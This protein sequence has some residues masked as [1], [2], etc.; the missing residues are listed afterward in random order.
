MQN[1]IHDFRADANYLVDLRGIRSKTAVLAALGEALQL[2]AH[3]GRNF[4]ALADCLMDG[5]W[6]RA[7]TISI[8]LFSTKTAAKVLQGD[9][10]TLIEIFDEASQWW[11]ER[12][13][14]LHVLLV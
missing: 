12:G 2:P 14:T 7:D 3:Y 13:K 8:V 9:W 10:D 6:A 4:D 5:D 11:C 1:G